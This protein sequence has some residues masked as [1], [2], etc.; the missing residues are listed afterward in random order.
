MT[1]RNKT[2]TDIVEA[3]RDAKLQR[4]AINPAVYH[5]ST[6]QF[7][8]VD[9]YE[10]AQADRHN[11]FYYGRYGTPT[12]K[13]L[14]RAIETLEGNGRTVAVGTG[15]GA[16]TTAFL[17]YLDSG[18]HVVLADN[19]YAPVR[20][21]ANRL[22]TR[23]GIDVSYFDSMDQTALTA[24]IETNTKMVYLEA[25][26]S[27]T[28]ET[29]D[30]PALAKIA[31]DAGALVAFDNTWATPYY[32]R[33]LEHGADISILAGTKYI[34]GHADLMMGLL[35]VPNDDF[36]RVRFVANYLGN[37]PGPDDCYLALRGLRTLA[38]RLDRHQQTALRLA[39]WLAARD[40]VAQVMHPAFAA[41]PG[42]A[43]WKRDFS[44]ASGLFGV[45]LSPCSEKAVKTMID[46]MTHFAIGA[47]WGGYESM[48]TLER[49]AAHRTASE[50]RHDG[51]V[52][53]IH[54]GL[55][56]ADDLIADIDAGLARLRQAAEE[57]R[58]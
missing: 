46:G 58:E 15:L 42:H 25:P 52:I 57:E 17:A 56:D 29:P 14:E 13:A 11:S 54:A 24:A 33:P 48:M 47:S 18:D 39:E 27:L 7:P 26:G 55:E 5:A 23:F 16:I 32:F 51:P 2:D 34:G 41:T 53:R 49:P 22:L 37:T 10:T 43:N 28:F 1:K 12:T 20:A 8:T 35:T 21:V 30:I 4:G 9:A 19:I 31:H 6:V 45:R 50:W 40:E 3:G 36:D 38:V 44:G